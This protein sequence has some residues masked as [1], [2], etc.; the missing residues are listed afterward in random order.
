MKHPEQKEITS[1]LS[2]LKW[3]KD[4]YAPDNSDIESH[5]D[6]FIRQWEEIGN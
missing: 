3:I 2:E 4:H 5:L 1:L 6:E